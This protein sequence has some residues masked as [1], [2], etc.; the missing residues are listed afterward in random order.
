MMRRYIGKL[1]RFVQPDP[2]D[3]SYDLTDPQSLNRYVY[4][5]NDPANLLDPLGLDPDVDIGTFNAGEIIAEPGT[6]G[7]FGFGGELGMVITPTK[8]VMSGPTDPQPPEKPV[9]ELDLNK[10]NSCLGLFGVEID[11]AT[12]EGEA[13]VY[14]MR[15]QGSFFVKDKK[16]GRGYGI[17]TDFTSKTRA[18][19]GG[20]GATSPRLPY[21][22]WVANDYASDARTSYVA[23]MAAQIHEIGN[24]L[25]FLTG[26]KPRAKDPN[27][28]KADKDSGMALEECVFGGFVEPGGSVTK[29]L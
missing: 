15:G 14:D 11:Y 4:V 12:Q 22:N 16:T 13:F 18:Q 26:K 8:P 7:T 20:T 2:S 3:G 9:V 28:R 29:K 23:L 5:Q 21:Y 25:S 6:V 1:H 17:T 10:L 24:S 19:L 27:L